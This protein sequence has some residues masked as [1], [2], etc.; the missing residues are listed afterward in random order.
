MKATI[1]TI[2]TKLRTL[3]D[4]ALNALDPADMTS[5]GQQALKEELRRRESPEYGVLRAEQERRE[6]EYEE[7]SEW[8]RR[9]NSR[10]WELASTIS[11]V[12]AITAVILGIFL[13]TTRDGD[14]P[15]VLVHVATVILLLGVL[16]AVLLF[17]VS[18]P[19]I[20]PIERFMIFL[21]VRPVVMRRGK[22]LDQK[23]A[24]LNKERSVKLEDRFDHLTKEEL[25][26]IAESEADGEW[27]REAV[28]AAR[29]VLSRRGSEPH[30]HP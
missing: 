25:L 27:T 16:G 9:L 19:S 24:T 20:F 6:R 11:L 10:S 22:V 28:L 29:N 18:P 21:L 8:L 4:E 17:L 30:N 15:V 23:P 14:S 26:E 13:I 7:R 12:L 3:S 2:S 5:E 1:Q